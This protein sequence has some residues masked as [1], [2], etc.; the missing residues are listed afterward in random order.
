MNYGLEPVP[1]TFPVASIFPTSAIQK[2]LIG[3]KDSVYYGF[4]STANEH[5]EE[6][7]CQGMGILLDNEGMYEGRFN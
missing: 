3:S 6:K 2:Q 1:L 4:S 5:A 7:N